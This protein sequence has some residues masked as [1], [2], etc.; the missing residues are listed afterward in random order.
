MTTAALPR[1]KKVRVM[2]RQNRKEKTDCESLRLKTEKNWEVA[3]KPAARN[4]ACTRKESVWRMGDEGLKAW[5]RR[6]V[7]EKGRTK[8]VV[9]AAKDQ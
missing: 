4:R 9:A 5:E 3:G 8:R 6:R 1:T 7:A 2:G